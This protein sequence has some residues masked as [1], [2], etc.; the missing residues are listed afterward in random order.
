[1]GTTAPNVAVTSSVIVTCD[2]CRNDLSTPNNILYSFP[3]GNVQFGAHISLQHE[4]VYTEIQDGQFYEMTIS[5]LDQNL[6]D[7][8]IIDKQI[9]VILSVKNKYEGSDLEQKK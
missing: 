3:S 2:I 7:I 6:K 5:F 1:M 4:L 8:S 9:N